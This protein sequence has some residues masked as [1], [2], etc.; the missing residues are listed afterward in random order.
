[1]S[2]PVCLVAASIAQLLKGHA[3]GLATG[4]NTNVL[5][6]LDEIELEM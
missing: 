5:G 3:T 1:M 4:K 2:L 6:M